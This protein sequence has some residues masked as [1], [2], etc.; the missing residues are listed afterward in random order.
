MGERRGVTHPCLKWEPALGKWDSVLG[1]MVGSQRLAGSRRR[2]WLAP[3]DCGLEMEC[4]TWVRCR[5]GR[6]VG[7]V[8]GDT[9]AVE[10]QDLGSR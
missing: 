1:R 8:G 9:P 5:I 3:D 6:V 10:F 2:G 7:S 4:C